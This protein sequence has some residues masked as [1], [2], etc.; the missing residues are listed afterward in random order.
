M[1]REWLLRGVSADELKKDDSQKITPQTPREKWDNFWYH[2]KWA[3][4]GAVAAVVV[5]AVFLGQSLTRVQPDYL[6]CMVT[7]QEVAIETDKRLEEILTQYATDVNGDGQ[8]R[9]EVTCHNVAATV[10]GEPNAALVT[11]QQS[12]MAHIVKHDVDLWV[13]D[14]TYYTTTLRSALGDEAEFLQPLTFTVEGV[15]EDGKYWN[16]QDAA[17]LQQPRESDLWSLQTQQYWG[18]RVT[19][20]TASEEEKASAAAAMAL[21]EAFATAQTQP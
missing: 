8:I 13:L 18:V 10:D 17:L 11:N 21:L 4:V 5:L 2:Y 19:A 14:P 16:W 3:V 12:V 7:S 15:S 9:V 1:A 6:I 20:E